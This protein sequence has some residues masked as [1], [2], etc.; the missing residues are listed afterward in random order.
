MSLKQRRPSIKDEENRASQGGKG[1]G[2]LIQALTGSG[3]TEGGF[4]S[5]SEMSD[6][7]SEE[8]GDL[9]GSGS[10]SAKQA[11]QYKNKTSYTPLHVKA[12][13]WQKFVNRNAY[14]SKVASADAANLEVGLN[15]LRNEQSITREKLN[16]DFHTGRITLEDRLAKEREFAIIDHK[17]SSALKEKTKGFDI[18][19]K[20]Q[21]YL[22]SK[23]GSAIRY[24]QPNLHSDVSD[25]SD[26]GN[27]LSVEGGTRMEQQGLQPTLTSNIQ[28][29][30][31]M[32]YLTNPSNLPV[33]NSSKEADLNKQSVINKEKEADTNIKKHLLDEGKN[34][35]FK[36]GDSEFTVFPNGEM[37]EVA[38]SPK[39]FVNG[40]FTEPKVTRRKYLPD[41][42][43][44]QG[45][46]KINGD[47]SIDATEDVKNAVEASSIKKPNT[48][49]ALKPSLTSTPPVNNIGGEGSPGSLYYKR[50]P[51]SNGMFSIE[52]N[53]FELPDDP[54][55]KRI[56]SSNAIS[57]AQKQAYLNMLYKNLTED[58][59]LEK[60]RKL[61][62]S[63]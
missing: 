25:M 28:S 17:L 54:E 55:T 21:D 44:I 16:N 43:V 38:V 30:Q 14:D 29:K 57:P 36:I 53:G 11:E 18:A 10:D 47:G 31:D 63:Y 52:P 46:T 9:Q 40:K 26:L 15:N 45:N 61:T 6:L 60:L 56:M 7:T 48:K 39:S 50:T 23:K 5:D 20:Q 42:S 41:G 2:M 32:D 4:T 51:T 22:N 49:P 33:I 37:E 58:S 24:L 12:S 35:S 59:T 8:Q 34:R 1:L 27:I 19:N 3:T 62:S 13:G